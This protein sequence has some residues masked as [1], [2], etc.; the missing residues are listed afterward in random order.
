MGLEIYIFNIFLSIAN[1]RRHSSSENLQ[2]LN[3]LSN[4][5]NCQICTAAL[6]ARMYVIHIG[7]DIGHENKRFQLSLSGCG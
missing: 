3:Q 6:V 1:H 7:I 2:H 5:Y 4:G